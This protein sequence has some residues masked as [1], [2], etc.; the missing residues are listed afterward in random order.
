MLMLWALV[1]ISGSIMV[2]VLIGKIGNFETW[3]I[4]AAIFGFVIFCLLSSFFSYRLLR[5]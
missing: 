4:T 2:A 1:A 3:R 5:K